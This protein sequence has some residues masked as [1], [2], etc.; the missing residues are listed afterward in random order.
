[1]I[2]EKNLRIVQVMNVIDQQHLTVI[3]ILIIQ[4]TIMQSKSRNYYRYIVEFFFF[5]LALELKLKLKIDKI[6]RYY[7]FSQK[8][9]KNYVLIICFIWII[10][11]CNLFLLVYALHLSL[12]WFI[13]MFSS[14][15]YTRKNKMCFCYYSLWEI[16]F[17][18]YY[19]IRNKRWSCSIESIL[20]NY[21]QIRLNGFS[22]YGFQMT[23]INIMFW[24]NLYKP[25]VKSLILSNR[26]YLDCWINITLYQI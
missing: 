14:S 8:D 21:N 6:S 22:F 20:Q 9:F 19:M 13:F 26:K 7:S 23:K 17:R 18:N 10:L 15:I 24:F 11:C 3:I 2:L 25:Y 4:M 16:F 12:I 1:M 5:I